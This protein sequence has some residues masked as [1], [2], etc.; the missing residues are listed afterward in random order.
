MGLRRNFDSFSTAWQTESPAM[1][2][3]AAR[4]ASRRQG[5]ELLTRRGRPRRVYTWE[6][7]PHLETPYLRLFVARPA[8]HL[9]TP[10]RYFV[11]SSL[12][13]VGRRVLQSAWLLAWKVR[14]SSAVHIRP[15]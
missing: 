5:G 2:R 8:A 1:V 12:F 4:P 13:S 14:C 10:A 6:S 3:L 9:R 7:P 11:W 15:W